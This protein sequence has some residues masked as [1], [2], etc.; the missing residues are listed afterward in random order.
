MDNKID[1]KKIYEEKK[2]Q[3]IF[4]VE[5]FKELTGLVPALLIYA[6]DPDNYGSQKYM[7]LKQKT[8]EECGIYTK[9]VRLVDNDTILKDE[10]ERTVTFSNKYG[11]GN[12]V[13]DCSRDILDDGICS[14]APSILQLP[15]A[16]KYSIQASVIK[17]CA[18][19]MDFFD[20]GSKIYDSYKF[21][22]TAKAVFAIIDSEVGLDNLAGKKVAI[23]GCRS[24]TVGSYL[25]D[26]L[27]SKNATV[28]LYHS[29]S[30]I[31][32]NEFED[33]DIVISCVGKANL[34]S[35]KHFGENRG[36]ICID[37]GVSRNEETGKV[38]GDFNK[39]I[40]EYQRYTP[41]TNGVGLLTRIFL[42]DSLI[43]YNFKKIA[44]CYG[45]DEKENKIVS[46]D[47]Y[48]SARF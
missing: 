39:D 47:S 12:T 16:E 1:C 10:T 27:L 40:R 22:A 13:H 36:C 20:M 29:K 3:I 37:I 45:Y 31:K 5:T 21:P 46:V 25:C 19:D 4:D 6:G 17:K 44:Y 41:Y 43:Q 32:E 35:Q 42:M 14:S 7:Q 2:Q 9:V 18:D 28:F 15:I 8:A 23:V 24:K 38:N 30:I 26:T 33:C 34:I 48:T 11:V